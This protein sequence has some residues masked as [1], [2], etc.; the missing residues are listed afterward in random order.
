MTEDLVTPY[1]Q[2]DKLTYCG[3]ACA[4]MVLDMAAVGAGLLDQTDLYGD[5]QPHNVEPGWATSPAGL[6][7]SLNYRKPAAFAKYFQLWALD[8]ED[9]ISRKIIWTIHHYQVSPVALVFGLRHWIAIRGFQASAAPGAEDDVTYSITGFFVN[10]PSPRT[11]KTGHIPPHAAGDLCGHGG[12]RGVSDEY[13]AYPEWQNTY[14]T[15]VDGGSVW[16]GKYVAVC[17]P[18][19]PP[20]RTGKPGNVPLRRSGEI[21]L[22]GDEAQQQASDGLNAHGLLGN[23]RYNAEF[24]GS[25]PVAPLLVKRLDRADSFYYIVPWR[26]ADTTG[27]VVLVD[28]RTGELLQC[29]VR[30]DPGDDIFGDLL[31]RESAAD[32]VV[33]KRVDRARDSGVISLRP[34]ATAQSPTLV[35]KPCRESLS[36]LYPFHLFT[37]GSDQ[38]YVRIDGE[39]F[40]E[41]HDHIRGE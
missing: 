36:P 12:K 23:F 16:L 1:H 7:W 18:D 10:N 29:A 35:W 17:D 4:Q 21:L 39:V 22:S 14:M 8:T 3:P 28:A 27:L 13:I 31:S 11:P 41:L 30:T 38:V 26:K 34:Q 9:S 20:T 33:G 24:A 32:V 40:T 6:T 19:L 25:A 37:S 5:I 2:Q 15:G